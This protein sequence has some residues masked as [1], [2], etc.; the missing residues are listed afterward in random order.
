VG[1]RI[2]VRDVLAGLPDVDVDEANSGN[3]D[4]TRRR[5]F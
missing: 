4:G 5:W 2:G 3:D 1:T